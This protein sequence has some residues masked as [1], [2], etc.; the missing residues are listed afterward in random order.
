MSESNGSR[1]GNGHASKNGHATKPP[2]AGVGG[3]LTT[4]RGGC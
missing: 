1:N 4:A 2:V 3:G